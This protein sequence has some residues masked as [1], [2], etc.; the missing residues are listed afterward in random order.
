MPMMT[1][2]DYRFY[3]VSNLVVGGGMHRQR[4]NTLDSFDLAAVKERAKA[5]AGITS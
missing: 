1:G 2:D 3:K 4:M 5:A